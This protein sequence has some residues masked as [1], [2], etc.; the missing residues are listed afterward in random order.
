V[1][2]ARL[3]PLLAVVALVSGH[4]V[5][6]R[7]GASGK[8]VAPYLSRGDAEESLLEYLS[9]DTSISRSILGRRFSINPDLCVGHRYHYHLPFL[10]S[11]VRAFP[12][13]N[14]SS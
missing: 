11:I 6:L 10:G 2:L 8:D 12:A 14:D 3:D 9:D 1:R 4:L 13:R 5:I 7:V